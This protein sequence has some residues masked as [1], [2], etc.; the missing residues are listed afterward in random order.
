MI[1]NYESLRIEK[2]YFLEFWRNTPF[3]MICDESHRIK[4]RHAAQSKACIE[5]GRLAKRRYLLSGTFVANKPEDIWN[6]INF[7]DTGELLGS[8]SNFKREHCLVQTMYFGQNRVEKIV[9]YKELPKLKDKLSRIMLRRTKKQCLD[10]PRKVIQK[11]PVSMTHKQK[12]FYREI[13]KEILGNIDRSNPSRILSR[14]TYALEIASNPALIQPSAVV[15]RIQERLKKDP[16][17]ASL[18]EDLRFWQS[19]SPLSHEDSGKLQTLDDLLELYCLEE[20]RKVVLWS[21]FVGNIE[22]FKQRYQRYK[23]AIFY[24]KTSTK[25]REESLHRFAKDPHC[26]LFIGN[27]QAAGFG[28]N[29]VTSSLSI[30]FD[31]NFSTVDYQQAVD[32]IHRI[33]QTD[34]CHILILQSHESIDNFVDR[35]LDKK[36]ELIDYLQESD[37]TAA[38]RDILGV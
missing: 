34:T 29:L 3:V 33:G 28:L 17:K 14:M 24:G 38:F 27:P 25:E 23:P 18:R 7:L 6:Q 30:F 13:C 36:I 9:G 2:N 12:R 35:L 26:R 19:K 20:K 37:E 4:N 8:F 1:I 21:F 11:I 31:R 15:E 32:R 10:L 16:N 22:M 5:I